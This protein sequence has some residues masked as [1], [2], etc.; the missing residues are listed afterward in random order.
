MD[1]ITGSYYIIDDQICKCSLINFQFN[2]FDYQVYEVLRTFNNIPVF[3]SDHLNRLKESLVILGISE[4]YN[5]KLAIRIISKLLESNSFQEGNIKFLFRH[6]NGKSGYASYFIP[7]YYPSEKEYKDGVKLLT[8]PIARMNPRI[9]QVLVN[10]FIRKKIETIKSTNSAYE[11]LL[12]NKNGCITEGSKSNLFLIKDN[13]LYSAPEEWI[14]LGIT[15]K[16]ILQIC[17]QNKLKY[18][19]IIIKKSEL[20][21][22]DAAFICGTSPKVLPAKEIDGIPFNV[23]H[24][25]IEFIKNKYD[26]LLY[27]HI[28]S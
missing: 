7:H 13:I 18:K 27:C 1:L 12:I 15:R 4:N 22:Y 17:A 2:N 28:K 20:S 8:Y 24:P 9:K 10:E 3:L 21:K 23:N 16:Y 19:E 25:L 26:D 14:L 11:I 6:N 5:E